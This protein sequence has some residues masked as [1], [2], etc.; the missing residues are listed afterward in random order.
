VGGRVG[1]ELGDG[2]PGL[3]SSGIKTSVMSQVASPTSNAAISCSLLWF[4]SSKVAQGKD[5]TKYVVESKDT[6]NVTL[7]M[8]A[9]ENKG[10]RNISA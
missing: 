1:R 10:V 9:E 5:A 4:V 2:A 8:A 7:L 6:Q 3:T